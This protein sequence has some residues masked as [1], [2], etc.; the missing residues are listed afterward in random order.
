MIT[1][2][3]ARRYANVELRTQY[4]KEDRVLCNQAWHM[5]SSGFLWDSYAT[6]KI[7]DKAEAAFKDVHNVLALELGVEYLSDRWWFRNFEFNGN[8]NTQTYTN[9]Y[10]TICK[11]FMMKIPDEVAKGDGWMK[12]RISLI[13]LAFATRGRQVAKA[14][15]ELLNSIAKAEY[16]E[17]NMPVRGLRVPGSRADGV[18]AVN[19]RLNE[20]YIG[21]VNDLNERLRLAQ[22][23]LTYHNGLI[24]LADDA[25]VSVQIAQPFWALVGNPPW[26]NVDRQMKEAIDCRDTGDR[27][28]AFH[29]VSA[30]ESCIKIVSD[31]KGWTKGTERGAA[32]Y[33]SNLV[34]IKNGAFLKA[35]EGELLTKLFSD[36]RN[37]FAHGAGQA[38]MPAMTAEQTNWTIDTSMNWIK[39]LVRRI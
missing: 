24:Q 31:T 1:E 21:L 4:F 13:E 9:S 27:M 15:S 38:A 6:E 20:T 22:Y 30:L 36:V 10:S 26:A 18:R 33:V 2:I 39:T 35:W 32:A 7:S 25:L 8:K 28:A 16:E 23:R 37:P 3:F 14:N 17:R 12:D 19:A 5:L 29:A 34:S 11:N